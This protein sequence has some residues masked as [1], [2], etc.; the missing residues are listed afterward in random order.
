V[1]FE[2][3][4]EMMVDSDLQLVSKDVSGAISLAG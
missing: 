3:L 2:K 1:T 4:V